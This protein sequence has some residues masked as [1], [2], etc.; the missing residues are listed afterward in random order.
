MEATVLSPQTILETVNGRT[1]R[2]ILP[3]ASQEV[4][5]GVPWDAAHACFTAAYWATQYWYATMYGDYTG[6]QWGGD[7]RDEV[8]G[9]L[10]GGFGITYEVNRA[11]FER[12][13]GCGLLNKTDVSEEDVIAALSKPLLVGKR[14]VGY[15]FP[16]QKGRFVY[17]ALRAL[18]SETP[19]T[20][21]SD[22]LRRWLMRLPG[23]GIKTASW[24]TRNVI[25][26]AQCAVID[27][28]I[29][30]A[31]VIMGLFRGD[32]K[33]PGDYERLEARFIRF[34]Q[35]INA[36]VTRLDV[37]IWCQMRESGAVGLEHFRRAA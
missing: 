16:R 30:R 4:V 35:A 19:S 21:D 14:Q 1:Q 36:D 34:A 29:F 10:L 9:C 13:K 7:L 28:H 2:L 24:I 26:G 8:V 18:N 23:I 33:L 20:E 11:A 27:V 5:Q 32:E 25:P 15:R 31:G 6:H 22:K 3:N 17:A 12:I 37:L